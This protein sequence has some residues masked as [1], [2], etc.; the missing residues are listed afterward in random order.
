MQPFDLK[1]FI[2]T[3]AI[4]PMLLANIEE[5]ITF[6]TTGNWESRIVGVSLSKEFYFKNKER[7]W[8]FLNTVK[9]WVKEAELTPAASGAPGIYWIQPQLN[10]Q[11]KP[12]SKQL[13]LF[14]Q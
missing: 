8:R 12:Q 11:P 10:Q 5:E 9:R 6:H 14:T 7:S 1:Q 3:F 4:N 13:Q 2:E